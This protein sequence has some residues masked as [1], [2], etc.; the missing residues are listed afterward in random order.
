MIYYI[1]RI[2]ILIIHLALMVG[3]LLIFI[4]V[5][6]NIIYNARFF[7]RLHPFVKKS[8]YAVIDFTKVWGPKSLM[9]YIFGQILSSLARFLGISF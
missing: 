7:R 2:T 4:Y 8:I 1:G 5:V 6:F 9:L 3:L